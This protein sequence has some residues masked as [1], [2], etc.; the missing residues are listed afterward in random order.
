MSNIDQERESRISELRRQLEEK[1]IDTSLWGKGEA[2]TLGHLQKEIDGGE[3]FLVLDESGELLRRLMIVGADIYYT[4]KDG[5]RYRLKE[6][7]QVFNDG[8]ERRRDY[9]HAVSEKMQ[10]DEDPGVAMIRGIREELGI[11]G[12]IDLKKTVADEKRISS[13]SYPGLN[14][15]YIRYGFEVLLNEEQFNIDG[16]VEEQEDKR[17]YFVWEEVDSSGK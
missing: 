5:K 9:G 2:K 4:S 1:G 7:R 11:E 17:T 16:Y 13:P 10:I 8:R 12:D 14:S 6:D 15:H 3:T